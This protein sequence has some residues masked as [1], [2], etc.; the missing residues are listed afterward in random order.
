VSN[1]RDNPAN[2]DSVHSADH[3]GKCD[4][5]TRETPAPSAKHGWTNLLPANESSGLG[6]NPAAQLG[7][8]RILDM[9]L[10]LSIE[11]REINFVHSSAIEPNDPEQV[12][13]AKAVSSSEEAPP[14]R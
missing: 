6:K 3:N 2:R 9:D 13:F 14:G 10:S 4:A 8:N 1:F 7:E 5:P 11:K 12:V